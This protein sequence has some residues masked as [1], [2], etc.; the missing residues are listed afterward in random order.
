M[1]ISRSN[2]K[3]TLMTQEELEASYS[4][5]NNLKSLNVTVGEESYEIDPE[6]SA[7]VLEYNVTVPTGTTMVNVEAVK[8]DSKA[9]VDGAGEVE[10]TEGLNTIPIVVTAPKSN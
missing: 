4:K 3:L 6:F 10:V 2:K 9:S 8:N 5:D 7:D 1:S